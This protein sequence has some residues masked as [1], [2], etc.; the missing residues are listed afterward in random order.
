MQKI[1]ENFPDELDDGLYLVTSPTTS[2]FSFFLLQI[3]NNTVH[4]R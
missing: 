1:T 3:E 4:W 2:S